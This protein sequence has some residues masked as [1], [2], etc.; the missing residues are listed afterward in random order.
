MTE[1]MCEDITEFYW[2][3]DPESIQMFDG[4]SVYVEYG[5]SL[6]GEETEDGIRLHFHTKA[7]H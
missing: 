5:D 7:I 2:E 1:L 3:C 4:T 6:W